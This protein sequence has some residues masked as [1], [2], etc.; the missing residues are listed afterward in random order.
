MWNLIQVIQ[1]DLFIKQKQT[2][3][4]QTQTPSYQKQNAGMRDKL[5]DWD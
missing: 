3:S 4:F 2:Q 5:G 1:K